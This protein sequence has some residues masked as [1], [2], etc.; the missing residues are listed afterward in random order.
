MTINGTSKELDAHW[1]RTPA[2]PGLPLRLQAGLR[3]TLAVWVRAGYPRETCG[4][5]LG[6]AEGDLVEVL[7][8]AQAQNTERASNRFNLAPQ[9]WIRIEREAREQGLDVVGIWHSHPDHPPRPSLTDFEGAWEGYSYL[10][11]A[12]DG[13]SR[14]PFRSWR[15]EHDAFVEQPIEVTRARGTPHGGEVPQNERSAPP[16]YLGGHW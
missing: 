5:L 6:R 4:L 7:N 12:I 16:G 13:S 3:D 2:T 1:V 15:L 10:I 9:D 8:V 14:G 11:L